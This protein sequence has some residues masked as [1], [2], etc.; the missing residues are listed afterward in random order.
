L[1]DA[2]YQALSSEKQNIEVAETIVKDSPDDDGSKFS[3]NFM[4]WGIF[5]FTLGRHPCDRWDWLSILFMVYNF[6]YF[7]ECKL[8]VFA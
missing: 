1:L 6:I 5:L 8:I 3:S 7:K 4:P 2:K